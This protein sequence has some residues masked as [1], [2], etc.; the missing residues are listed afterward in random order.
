MSPGHPQYQGGE[1]LIITVHKNGEL[2]L[3]EQ[4]IIAA[5]QSRCTQLVNCLL[6]LAQSRSIL[7]R[8]GQSSNSPVGGLPSF[9]KLCGAHST[10]NLCACRCAHGQA[11][12]E[13]AAPN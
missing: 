5:V 10:C 11:Q 1:Q 2:F 12:G 8:S 4:L 6:W 13:R 3:R 9:H 7:L